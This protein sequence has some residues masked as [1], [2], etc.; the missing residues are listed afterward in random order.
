MRSLI[1]LDIVSFDAGVYGLLGNMNSLSHC[2]I[3][4]VLSIYHFIALTGHHRLSSEIVDIDPRAGKK[5][6]RGVKV[7]DWFFAKNFGSGSNLTPSCSHLRYPVFNVKACKQ[8]RRLA[9][10][11]ATKNKVLCVKCSSGELCI[12]S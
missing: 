2:L 7:I 4:L 12:G 9:D 11:A 6:S 10:A 1:H 5:I 8:L 3:G